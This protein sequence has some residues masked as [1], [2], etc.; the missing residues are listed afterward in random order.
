MCAGPGVTR[1]KIFAR[2]KSEILTNL[3][4]NKPRCVKGICKICVVFSNQ[5][6]ERRDQRGINRRPTLAMYLLYWY[7]SGY[8]ESTTDASWQHVKWSLSSTQQPTRYRFRILLNISAGNRA[9][10]SGFYVT[11]A[12]VITHPNLTNE[13]GQHVWNI[14]LWEVL[15]CV[16]VY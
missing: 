4:R 15:I 1:N 3:L 5:H 11:Q 7:E 9:E 8:R 6:G 13:T 12:H 2:N 16:N 14:R 10:L